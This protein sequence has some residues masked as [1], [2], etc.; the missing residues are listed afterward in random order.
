MQW[1]GTPESPS[2]NPLQCFDSTR[3][4]MSGIVC[5]E[6]GEAGGKGQAIEFMQTLMMPPSAQ[7]KIS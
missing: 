7:K 4:I 3:L 2:I 5:H 1:H 6:A